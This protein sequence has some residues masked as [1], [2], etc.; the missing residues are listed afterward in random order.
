MPVRLLPL[1]IQQFLA[2]R[3]HALIEY[4][5]VKYIFDITAVTLHP[6]SQGEGI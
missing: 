6:I 3:K 4:K 1:S 5:E 2:I